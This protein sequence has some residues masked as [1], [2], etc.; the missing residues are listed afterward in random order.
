MDA[1]NE[2]GFVIVAAL[3]IGFGP[4]L[5]ARH[6]KPFP[7]SL[8]R[9]AIIARVV[10]STLRYEILQR[11][12]AGIGDASGYYA[13]GVGF[14]NRLWR[15]DLVPL[16]PGY[17]F[18]GR[19]WWG[20]DF[21]RK[22]SGLVVSVTGPTIRGEF[23]AF[24]LLSF[25]GLYAIAVAFWRVAGDE[26]ARRFATLLWL[27][28]SLWFWPASVGKEAII[29]LGI[30]LATVGYVGRDARPQWGI[31]F[32][33]L[34]LVFCVRPHVAVVL[35]MAAGIA[36][37]LASWKD[38]G[39]RKIVEAVAITVVVVGTLYFARGALGLQD[40][41]LEGMQEFVAFRASQTV[42]GGSN[43]GGLPSGPLAPL[44]GFVNVWMRPFLWEAHN[45]TGLIAAGEMLLLWA[46]VAYFW[47]SIGAVAATWRDSR[48]LRFGLPF[49]AGYTLMLGLNY[50][51]LGIIARQRTIAFPFF[52]AALSLVPESGAA[53]APRSSRAAMRRQSR[54]TGRRGSR[55]MSATKAID[56]FV[57]RDS[58]H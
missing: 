18:G 21:L 8:V 7:S 4:K 53:V 47:P 38:G 48:F 34:L 30:G 14:A 15:G 22:V 54:K 13:S 6:G 10:G 36:Q 44:Q 12:Y 31:M 41:D 50:G 9:W 26:E 57:L 39:A 56:P 51:N 27:W 20:T 24:S 19:G 29:L 16:A 2:I 17:W 5:L 49:L 23:L 45:V 37:W 40:A 55:E 32:S 11:F 43:L 33:G 58:R 28:P 25:L 46:L 52:L 1:Y 35:V 3:A 42:Q